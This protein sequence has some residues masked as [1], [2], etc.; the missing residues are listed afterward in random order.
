VE[1]SNL[2]YSNVLDQLEES[3]VMMYALVLLNPK[4]SITDEESRNRAVVLDRG[5]RESGGLRIDV[6][7]SMSFEERLVAIARVLRAQQRVVYARP[8][9]LIPPERFEVAA[10]PP[11][12]RAYGAPARGQE[13]K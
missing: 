12:L 11:G 3:G 6:L 9:S 2:H 13:E 10:A 5:P 8:E 4:A 7:T 1:F